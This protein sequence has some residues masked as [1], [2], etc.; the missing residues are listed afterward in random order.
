VAWLAIEH[1]GAFGTPVSSVQITLTPRVG[2]L[3]VVGSFGFVDTVDLTIAD[4]AGHTW[5]QANP[6]HVRAG[7]DVG[8]SWYTRAT[9]SQLITIT[10]TKSGAAQYLTVLGS[11]F[12]GAYNGTIL[13]DT[14]ASTGGAGPPTSPAVTPV[15]GGELIWAATLDAVTAVGSGYLKGADD[16]D[17][18]WSEYRFLAPGDVENKIATFVGGAY[19]VLIATFRGDPERPQYSDIPKV[20]LQKPHRL[21]A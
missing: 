5:S 13:G 14:D 10:V 9:V 3:I 20:I 12:R 8:E 6:Q 21:E 7:Q 18:D 15:A 1:E 16:G 11:V 4:D 2:D 19:H 17:T